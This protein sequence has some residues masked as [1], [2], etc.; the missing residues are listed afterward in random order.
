MFDLKK[1]EIYFYYHLGVLN[2]IIKNLF[3]NNS[4]KEVIIVL[5]AERIIIPEQINMSAEPLEK[6]STMVYLWIY[7]IDG[8]L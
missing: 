6:N 5:S 4:N 1:T 8:L 7:N 2:K 3:F